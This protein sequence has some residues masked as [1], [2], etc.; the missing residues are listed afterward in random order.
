MASSVGYD[1]INCKQIQVG[2]T[3]SVAGRT[4]RNAMF[5]TNVT[6]R[7][8]GWF[9]AS[10]SQLIFS[11]TGDVTG[12]ASVHNCELY[13][14]DK[15]I[16]HGAYQVLELNLQAP[17]NCLGSGNMGAPVSFIKFQLS[18]AAKAAL[19]D[20]ANTCLFEINGADGGANSYV[21]LAGAPGAVDGNIRIIIDGAD[22]FIPIASA[23]A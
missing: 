10:K 6:A 20:V 15:Q 3:E 8:G 19:E 14:P 13:L 22:W 12:A 11:A 1:A 5:E 9:N 23:G 4:G 2:K 18:G 21:D 17:A 16:T 7:L